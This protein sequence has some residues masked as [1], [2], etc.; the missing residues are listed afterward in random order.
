MIDVVL[1]ALDE[2]D[3]LPSVIAGLPRGFRPIVVDNASTDHTAAIA[4]A[5]G[6]DVVIEPVRG[7]GAACFAGLCASTADVVCFMDCD[8]SLDGADLPRVSAPVV[9]GR[10]DL[11]LGARDRG[12][13]DAWTLHTRLANAGLARLLSRRTGVQLSDLGPMRAAPRRALL[14]LGIGDRRFGWPLEMV[15]RAGAAGWRI[16]EVPVA[17]QPRVG[18]SKV[19]GTARGTVLTVL[20]MTKALA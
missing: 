3:A 12:A 13:R 17:Y 6:V 2:Q 9:A 15:V 1:P 14:E 16:E 5:L 8:A 10:A 7:Y 19:T 18:R 20:D 4:R 11:V